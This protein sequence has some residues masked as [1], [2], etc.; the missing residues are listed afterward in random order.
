VNLEWEQEIKDAKSVGNDM[1]V[2]LLKSQIR[3]NKSYMKKMEKHKN[4][5]LGKGKLL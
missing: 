3:S 4:L 5:I 1:G 2:L